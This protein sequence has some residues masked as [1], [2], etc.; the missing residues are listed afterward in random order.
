MTL[1]VQ[2]C[3]NI[4]CPEPLKK[5]DKVVI[6]SPSGAVK[7][8]FVL[9]EAEALK[10]QGWDAEIAPNA[11]GKYL[12]YSGTIHE[13]I[14]DFKDALLD[15]E[16][17]AIFCARGGYGAVQ[18]LATLDGMPLRE[19]AKWIVGYSDISALHALMVSNGI[20]SI[21][22]PMARHLS[23]SFGSDPDSEKLFSIL[24]GI[25]PSYTFASNPMNRSGVAEGTIV[26]GN[27]AVLS[28]LIST[29]YDIFA[30][31]IILFIEDIAEP[32]YKVERI[33]YQLKLSGK[34]A[35]IAGLIVGQFTD[36]KIVDGMPTMYETILAMVEEYD[37][38]VVFD[39]PIGHVSYNVPIPVSSWANL[40]VDDN[41]IN[42]K[43]SFPQNKVS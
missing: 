17:K 14:A 16:V 42:L 33:F 3:D 36:Y 37:F 8:E 41:R 24:R 43:C 23:S 40:S 15:P 35:G 9:G 25:C 29:P 38:P 34:L 32:V 7:P 28:A 39:A 1:N 20:V 21:H 2:D 6:V 31:G 27:L 19:C 18:L 30:P 5:G 22:A 26:G 4:I 13:R 11:M 10:R 12:S